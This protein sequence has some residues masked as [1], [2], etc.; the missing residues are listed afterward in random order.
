[1][2]MTD[3]HSQMQPYPISL[4]GG[5]VNL[6]ADFGYIFSGDLR[7]RDTVYYDWNNTGMEV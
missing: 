5:G 7:I 2:M 3:N 1:M 6:T 4:A